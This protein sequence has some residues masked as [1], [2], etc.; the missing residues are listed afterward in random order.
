MNQVATIY[1]PEFSICTIVSNQE[2]YAEM[3]SSFR[4]KGFGDDCEYLVADNTRSNNEDAYQAINRFLQQATGVYIIIVHQDVRC[5]DHRSVLSNA[6]QELEE[7]DKAWAVCGNAGCKGYKKCYYHLENAGERR[8]SEGLPK[9]VN[10][11]DENFL[12]VKNSC[13]LQVTPALSGFHLYG[14]DICLQ[15][16]A[17]GYTAYVIPFLVN[18]LSLGN[19]KDLA[20]YLPAFIKVHENTQP[21]RFV[22]TTCTKFWLGKNE[23]QTALMNSPGVFGLVKF[24]QR[25]KGLFI[26]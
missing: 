26:L 22:Q 19:L 23:R 20:A 16:E 21:A 10:S 24:W 2:E 4:D 13:R 15:A 17:C 12:V 5:I 1:M 8:I 14:T 9:Q 11:L 25:L 3:K 7:K 18:H 6:I